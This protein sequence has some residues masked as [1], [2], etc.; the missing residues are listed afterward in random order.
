MNTEGLAIGAAAIPGPRTADQNPTS[1]PASPSLASPN[2]APAAPV[3]P[4]ARHI[5][6]LVER[7]V[8]PATSAPIRR[9]ACCGTC[10]NTVTKPLEDGSVRT[11]CALAVSRRGGPDVL[12]SFPACDL[13]LYLYQPKE[14]TP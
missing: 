2:T 10:A 5:Q 14:S 7:G 3:F 12:P 13:Y 6:V 1:V 4:L 8:H 11:R 9:D